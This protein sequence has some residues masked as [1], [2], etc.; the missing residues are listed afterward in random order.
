MEAQAPIGEVPTPSQGQW[1]SP[2][3]VKVDPPCLHELV[4]VV[5]LFSPD[6]PILPHVLLPHKSLGLNFNQDT[7]PK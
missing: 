4:V 2:S 3:F 5:H 6:S 1:N 7:P